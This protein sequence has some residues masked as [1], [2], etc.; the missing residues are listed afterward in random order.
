MDIP[1]F[2]HLDLESADKE[3]QRLARLHPGC[4]F[5]VLEAKR[6]WEKTDIRFVNLKDDDSDDE[7]EIPF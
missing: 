1:R 5:Y 6:Y 2:E 4:K 7:A 3:A